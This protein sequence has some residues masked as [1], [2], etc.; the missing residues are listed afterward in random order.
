MI[1][2]YKDECK[3]HQIDNCAFRHVE[4][5][6]KVIGEGLD[7]QIKIWTEEIENLKVEIIHLK[8]DINIK[9][10]ELSKSKLEMKQMNIKHTHALS[11]IEHA[12]TKENDYLKNQVNILQKENEAMKIKLFY[13]E[14][15]LAD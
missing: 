8:E 4:T 13:P 12:L 9:E 2:R 3:F 11:D 7:N 15:W 14:N 1:C 5:K 10:E 6:K